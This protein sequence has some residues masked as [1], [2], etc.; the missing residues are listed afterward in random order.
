MTNWDELTDDELMAELASAVAEPAPEV[1]ERRRAAAQAAFTWRT[2]DAELAELLHDSALEAGAA[3][4]SG[5]EGPRSLAFGRSGRTLEIEVDGDQVLGEVITDGEAS[6][7][8]KVTLRRPDGQDVT[9]EADASGFV[10]FSGV[11]SGLARFVVER[12]GWSLTT[13]WVTI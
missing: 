6:E 2:V 7:R 4:R 5:S 1:L 9:V 10:R 11:A 12:A 3:V 13:P 8:T